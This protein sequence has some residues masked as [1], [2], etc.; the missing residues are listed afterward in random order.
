MEELR[1]EYAAYEREAARLR[2]I[3]RRALGLDV[4]ADPEPA[5]EG[6]EPI[7]VNGDGK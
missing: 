6:G 2:A 4:P 3:L 1:E 7:R 5:S